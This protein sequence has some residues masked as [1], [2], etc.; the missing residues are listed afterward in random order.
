M[1]S[2]YSGR[3][4]VGFILKRSREG[5]EAFDVHEKSLGLYPSQHA[6]IAVLKMEPTAGDR[7]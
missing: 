7:E 3:E 6:A 2:V 4:C 5:Y 1:L